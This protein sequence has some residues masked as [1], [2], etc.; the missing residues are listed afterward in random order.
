MITFLF[1]I[2]ALQ[3]N[4]NLASSTYFAPPL[5]S[6]I[7]K[8]LFGILWKASC[9]WSRDQV[10]RYFTFINFLDIVHTI[11]NNSGMA[12][13][14]CKPLQEMVTNFNFLFRCEPKSSFLHWMEKGAKTWKVNVWNLLTTEEQALPFSGVF[15][16]LAS[17]WISVFTSIALK[18]SLFGNFVQFFLLWTYRRHLNHFTLFPSR[19]VLITVMKTF[20]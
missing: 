7:F 8:F 11:N 16:F 3:L 6:F 15:L 12:N 1:R 14:L 19:S 18:S 17:Q 20:R 9:N 13:C 4:R 2:Y 10:I 5:I